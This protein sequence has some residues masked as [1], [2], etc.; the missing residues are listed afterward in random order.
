[1]PVDTSTLPGATRFV[2]SIIGQ[3]YT[4]KGSS[5]TGF[6]VL[7]NYVL[8]SR[9]PLPHLPIIIMGLVVKTIEVSRITAVV[10]L[11]PIF[12]CL[13]HLEGDYGLYTWPCAP[14]LAQYVYSQRSHIVGK[15]ILEVCVNRPLDISVVKSDHPLECSL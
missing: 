13:K 1:M 8:I 12:L 11:V 7:Y 10:L 9:N 3:I 5:R 14:V 15:K 2:L 4:D 6:Q